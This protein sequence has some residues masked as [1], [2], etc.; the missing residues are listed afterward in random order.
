MLV[1][2]PP[3]SI[4]PQQMNLLRIVCSM[5]WSDGELSPEEADLMLSHFSEEF[6]TAEKPASMLRQEL[7]DYVSQNIPLEEL[8]P[9][10]KTDEDRALI[11]KLGYLVIQASR[12]APDEPLINLE[13][14]AAY[15]RLVSLLGLPEDAIAKIEA[16][17][18]TDLQEHDHNLLASLDFEL[19]EFFDH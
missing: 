15:H 18:E 7:Q 13:E 16:I 2:P 1:P 4:S 3:P 8:V 11:L 6:A 19:H 17:A 5:A 10:L 9:K 14:K 12:R